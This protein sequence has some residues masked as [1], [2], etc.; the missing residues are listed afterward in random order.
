MSATTTTSAAIL[1]SQ[2]TQD[3][4]Y[5]I[6]Y[7][8]NKVIGMV[9]KDEKLEG[10]QKYVAVQTELPQGGGITIPLAQQHLNPGIYKRYTITRKN[11]YTVARVSGEALKAAASDDG[12]LLNLW[13]REMDGAIYTCKRSWAIQFPRNGTGSRG[14]ISAG[15]NVGTAT[16][17]LAL[18][19]DI[20]NF[21]VGMTLQATATDGGTLRSAGANIVVTGID[22][23]NSTLTAAGNWSAAIAAIAASDFLLREGDNNGV[24][25]GMNAWVPKIAITNTL[26]NGLDRSPDPVR[27]AGQP[28]NSQG[29]TLREA[30]IESMA[31]IDVEGGEPDTAIF[32]PRDKA[33]L[34]KEFEGKSIYFKEV[35][36]PGSP[37]AAMGFDV[38]EADFDG[39]KLK[40]IA[41]MNQPRQDGYVTQWD[42]WGF[43]SL[44]PAPHIIMDDTL[45][46]L[47]VYNDDALEVRVVNRG[48]LE[49]LAAAY[50]V[51]LYNVGL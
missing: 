14:Q 26:F 39:H 9:R 47:R 5:W 36:S 6:N 42:T 10:D 24:I 35:T 33:T 38:I 34:V 4:V 7:V 19:S 20:T 28:L 22:R 25:Q 32:H 2:Y 40:V 18:A 16:I 13:E 48:D 11:D 31:R 51:H 27:Y 17:T 1:K 37:D 46:F 21:A 12:A 45:E 8:R 49:N 50:S 23:L 29:M 3:R 41:D 43:D 30:I 15:S 44:G